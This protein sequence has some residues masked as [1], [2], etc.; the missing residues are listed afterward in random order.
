M[1]KSP[2]TQK[3][4]LASPFKTFTGALLAGLIALPLAKMSTL[5]AQSFAEHPFISDNQFALKISVALRTLVV[6]LMT[7]ATGIFCVAALGL[8]ALSIQILW[9]NLRATPTQHEV[10]PTDSL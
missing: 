7:L 5:I 8:V 6:G 1:S 10:E 4:N 9:Q 3:S 2:P